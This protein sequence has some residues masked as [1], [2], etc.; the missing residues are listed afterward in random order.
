MWSVLAFTVDALA[1]A[2]QAIVGRELGAG[3]VAAARAATATMLRWGVGSGVLLGV[4]VVVIR[5]PLSAL[6]TPDPAVQ[7]YAAAALVVVGAGQL[8]SGYVFVADGVLMGA[9]DFGY[10]AWAML[11]VLA[12]YLPAVVVARALLGPP[13]PT[14]GAALAGTAPPVERPGDLVVLWIA[15]LVMMLA[16][17]ITLGA[18]LRSGRWA[19]SGAT[20]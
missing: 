2:A 14:A 12:A 5:G 7:R 4:L 15:F 1:I 8:V 18:R 20:R 6:F 3:R 11:G 16:R 17:A 10:L 9:G 19:V 13:D